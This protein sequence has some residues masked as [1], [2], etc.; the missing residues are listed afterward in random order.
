MT[1]ADRGATANVRALVERAQQGDS[2]ALE[3]L[4]LLQRH[5]VR[6]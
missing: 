1:A 4:Y 2:G 6:A 5:V 3:E